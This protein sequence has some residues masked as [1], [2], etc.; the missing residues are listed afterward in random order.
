MYKQKALGFSL[1]EAMIV[2]AI[3]G[4]LAAIAVPSYQDMIERNRLKQA[5]ESLKSDLQLART[6][7][8]K[9]SEDVIVSR[10][11]GVAGAWCYGLARKKTSSRTSCDCTET[12]IE[13][14][15]Y[16]N[17]KIVSGTNFSTTNM[18][19]SSNN[20]STFSFRRGTIGADSVTFST[21]NHAVRVVFSD[22]GRVRICTPSGSSGIL[23]YPICLN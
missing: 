10:K 4:I 1:V 18:E 23:N 19:S 12:N 20:N 22:V 5:V 21:N 7:A 9:R 17:I 6:E 11:T 13:D 8:I 3:I 14:A 2:V 15:D 16:C